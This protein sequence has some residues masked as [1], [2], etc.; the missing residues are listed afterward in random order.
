MV[1]LAKRIDCAAAYRT[2]E[3]RLVQ[4]FWGL[5]KVAVF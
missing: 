4:S 3:Q 1:F 2:N 5:L